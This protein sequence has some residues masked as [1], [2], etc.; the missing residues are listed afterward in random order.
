M[1]ETAA[2]IPVEQIPFTAVIHCER[3][4]ERAVSGTNSS[5]HIE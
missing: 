3:E 5:L 1:V 4:K 2:D